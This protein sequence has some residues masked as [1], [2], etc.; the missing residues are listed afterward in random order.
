MKGSASPF[1]L[2][3]LMPDA[4]W[5]SVARTAT[6]K[7]KFAALQAAQGM[8]RRLRE[9]AAR[10]EAMARKPDPDGRLRC[11]HCRRWISPVK[12]WKDKTA[13]TRKMSWC[14]TCLEQR[15]KK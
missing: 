3:S 2:G 8:E 1:I 5:E 7:K 12:F 6:E 4:Y 14:K 15:T 9:T 11:A 13:R 10:G